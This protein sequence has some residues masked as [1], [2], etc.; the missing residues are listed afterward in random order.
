MEIMR[1][2]LKEV[3]NIKICTVNVPEEYIDAIKKLINENGLYP[4]R[5]ELIRSAVR[6][7]LLK[8]L[9]RAKLK[10]KLDNYDNDKHVNIAT[11]GKDKL[12]GFTT[13]KILRRLE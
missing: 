4:S 13:Y 7:F 1:K 5:S 8:E 10:L 11:D 12:N 6:Q 3:D 9:K 2:L